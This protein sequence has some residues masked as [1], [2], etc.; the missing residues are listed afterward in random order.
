MSLENTNEQSIHLK[1]RTYIE[2]TGICD[3]CA[4][5]DNFIEAEYENGC[6]AVEGSDLKIIDFS[7]QTGVLKVTGLVDGIYY[8][9]KWHNKK[10]KAPRK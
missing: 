6:I 9:D 5:A 8:I 3:V 1:N 10:K 4:F 2:L 7:S